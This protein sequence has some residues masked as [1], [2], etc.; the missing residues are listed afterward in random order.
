ME[1]EFIAIP[2]PDIDNQELDG[3]TSSE[4]SK[5]LIVVPNSMLR[6]FIINSKEVARE[7]RNVLYVGRITTRL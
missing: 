2:Y 5:L 1:G 4:L 6:M 3:V 7:M